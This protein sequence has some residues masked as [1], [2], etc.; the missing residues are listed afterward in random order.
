MHRFPRL[1]PVASP[2]PAT[3]AVAALL[4][5]AL[6]LAGCL[7]QGGDLT[8]QEG[9]FVRVHYVERFLSNGTVIASSYNGTW[10]EGA[11]LEEVPFEEHTPH[12]FWVFAWHQGFGANRTGRQVLTDVQFNDLDADGFRESMFQTRADVRNGSSDPGAGGPGSQQNRNVTLFD[13][14]AEVTGDPN[15]VT[16]GF[17]RALIG[18]KQG[19]LVHVEVQPAQAYGQPDPSR[20]RD[21]PRTTTD[22]PRNLTGQPRDQVEERSNWT[23]STGEGDLISY[24]LFNTTQVTARVLN[25]TGTT[26]SLYLFLDNGTEIDI[27]SL[28]EAEVFNVSTWRYDLFHK[29]NLG[30]RYRLDRPQGDIPFRVIATN[31]THMRLDFNDARAGKTIVYDARVLQVVRPG[32]E[33]A[34]GPTVDPW[35]EDNAVH[36]VAMLSG[37]T[38]LVATER[39][40]FL[41]DNF[42]RDW[43]PLSQ[44]LLGKEVRLL[45]ASEATPGELFAA[46]TD[47]G[48][49]HSGDMGR[50]WERRDEGLPGPVLAFA[51]SQADGDVLYALVFGEGV[52]RSSD[53]G[54]T[55]ERMTGGFTRAKG[56]AAGFTDP[57]TVWAATG[58]GLRRS[59]DGG[60]SWDVHTFA[61]EDVR[62]VAVAD[63]HTVVALVDG[64]V[65]RT[66]DSGETWEAGQR[67]GHDLVRLDASWDQ[68]RRMVAS[69]ATGAVFFSQNG[70]DFWVAIRNPE[71]PASSPLG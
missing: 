56:L 17:A 70:G 11:S 25:V 27:P 62:D 42:A 63:D 47:E 64:D 50:T 57:D 15:V 66:F 18:H 28:W 8:V 39:G 37:N 52:F 61:N 59:V 45:S 4:L 10:P 35:R 40:A 65:N 1:R 71:A 14:P 13:V 46:V 16:E 51:Q 58:T 69:N 20:V 36:D 38:V 67:G 24:T 30:E 22:R 6:P 53:R 26:V 9:D 41:S 68:P 2:S 12:Q 19:D 33:L 31:D 49:W 7:D 5:I 55:W 3:T 43:Y 29:P 60:A 21:L 23:A 44:A 54:A 32:E 48:L 34:R